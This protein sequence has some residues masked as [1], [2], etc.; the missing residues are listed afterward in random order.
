MTEAARIF[1]KLSAVGLVAVGIL[2]IYSSRG[3]VSIMIALGSFLVVSYLVF[4]GC[5]FRRLSAMNAAADA[6]ASRD[7]FFSSISVA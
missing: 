5:T 7:R 4:T 6:E 2:A 3:L 1:R